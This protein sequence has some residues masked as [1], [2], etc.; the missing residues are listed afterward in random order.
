MGKSL[1]FWVKVERFL[2]NNEKLR[3]FFEKVSEKYLEN[4]FEKNLIS[5]FRDFRNN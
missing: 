2:K 3:L 1:F 5:I 4:F